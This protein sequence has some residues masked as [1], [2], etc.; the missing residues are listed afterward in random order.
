IIPEYDAERRAIL[1]RN[2]YNS[3]FG[4]RVAFLASSLD[5]HGLTT[6]RTEFLGRLGDRRW[7]AALGRIG[8]SGHVAAGGD[9]CAAIQVHLDLAPGEV[10]EFHFLLGQGADREETL[11]VM[12]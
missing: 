9:P 1:A 6:D 3:E 4:S 11:S 10:A 7:P 8:L 12:D 5:P 2:P